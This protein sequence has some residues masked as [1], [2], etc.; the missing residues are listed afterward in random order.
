LL[1]E[2]L[3]K[4]LVLVQDSSCGSLDLGRGLDPDGFACAVFGLKFLE[5]LLT[6][7]ARPALV[8]A[9]ARKVGLLG[10]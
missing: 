1:L 10:L 2:Q 6:T 7:G 9:N 5:V 4:T 8:V 3:T